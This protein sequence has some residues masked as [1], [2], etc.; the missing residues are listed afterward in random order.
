MKDVRK[1]TESCI[2]MSFIICMPY[3][4]LLREMSQV[5]SDGYDT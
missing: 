1:G 2:M 3:K 4:V 5:G